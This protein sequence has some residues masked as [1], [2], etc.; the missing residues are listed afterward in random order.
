MT[1]NKIN[2]RLEQLID[3]ISIKEGK[4]KYIKGQTKYLTRHIKHISESSL[5]IYFNSLYPT[6]DYKLL[7]FNYGGSFDRHTCIK[8]RYDIDAYLV[9]GVKQNTWYS[10]NTNQITGGHLFEMV[11]NHLETFIDNYNVDLN[12]LKDFPYT[13]A[14]P[15]R[16]DFKGQSFFVDCIPAFIYNDN[17]LLVPQGMNSIKIVN[18]NLEA[19]ALSELNSIH[20]GN[21][22]KLIL[23][24][25][26]W[27][28]NW[29]KPLKSYVIERMGD[30][31]FRASKING[32]VKA[33]KTFFNQ[34]LN[35]IGNNLHIPDRVYSDRS[36][37]DDY[38]ESE[39]DSFYTALKDANIFAVKNK[40]QDLFGN[41]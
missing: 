33:V 6:L 30:I 35:I 23:L 15:I 14:I 11:R 19:L 28:I 3:R 7:Q 26:Y 20:N 22:T 4:K 2:H 1:S 18:P 41:F 29:D 24:L 25:K 32:W 37:L 8:H 34:S 38:T 5:Q 12:I 39:L 21:A 17:Y 40:W 16:I 13:H 36:I 27:N 31:I 10:Y 9:Y